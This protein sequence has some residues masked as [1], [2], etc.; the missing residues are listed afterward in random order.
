MTTTITVRRTL[1]ITALAGML[2]TTACTDGWDLDLRGKVGGLDTSAAARGATVASRPAA[3][4]RGVISYSDY[5][6]AVARRGDT[7]ASLAQ[8]VGQSPTAVAGVNGLTVDAVLRDGEIL[9]L[10]SGTTKAA[11][12][13][14]TPSVVD[15]SELSAGAVSAP[16]VAAA[17]VPVPEPIQHRVEP[18]ETAFTIARLYQVPVK[19]LAEWNGLGS[20]LDLR[21]GQTLLIPVVIKN[22]LTVPV[23]SAPGS[24]SLTPTPPSATRPQPRGDGAVQTA[25]AAAATVAPSAPVADLKPATSASAS[26]AVMTRPVGGSIIRAFQRGR[27]EGIDIGAAAGTSVKAAQGG[28]VVAISKDTNGVNLLVIQHPNNLLTVYTNIDGIS[29]QKGASVKRGQTIA[30][31]AAGSPSFLHFEVR[32]GM[33][34]VDPE[35]FL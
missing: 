35:E 34:S 20:D 19:S 27:N 22:D 8:R 7:V 28:R 33:E 11:T 16:V 3:D 18:G 31:V 30:K 15:V 25:A 1:H 12:T 24:G 10:P 29:V 26:R 4:G 9:S 32:R 23:V 17:S 21:E 2:L 14:L 6:V 5:D 13:V